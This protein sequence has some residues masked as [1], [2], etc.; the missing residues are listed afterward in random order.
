MYRQVR[1]FFDQDKEKLV[2]LVQNKQFPKKM[3]AQV[4]ILQ[5]DGLDLP[6]KTSESIDILLSL[7]SIKEK[8][9]ISVMPEGEKLW[10]CQ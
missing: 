8:L 7:Y 10:G 4:P 1:F 6:E 9:S 3:T 5:F 2:L